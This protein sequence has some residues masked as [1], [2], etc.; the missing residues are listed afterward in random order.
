MTIRAAR[1]KQW[2]AAAALA[3]VLL[4]L[5]EWGAGRGAIRA[6]FF[7]P[8]S[9][10]WARFLLLAE[11]GVLSR[12]TAATLMRVGA[13][14]VLSGL[15]GIALG[16]LMGFSATVRHGL[17]PIISFVYP[18]PAVLL[19]PVAVSAFG[20]SEA[21][22]ILTSAITPFFLVSLSTM[23]GVLRIEPTLLEAARNFGA[24]GW[25]LF[26][27]VLL[28]GALPF[29]FTGLRLG[30]GFSLIVVL[31]VEILLSPTGLGAYLW[32]MWELLRVENVYAALLVVAVIGLLSTYGLDWLGSR[33]LPW[34]TALKGEQP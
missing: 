2:L 9:R 34:H 25:R 26:S 30:L 14:F 32:E 5:W 4:L 19:L 7:P 29:I 33:L 31:A 15:P 28:P 21:A 10:I 23:S 3:A 17:S 24:S 20:R 8:P 1:W 16:L 22:L 6:F 12:H 27:K 18:V 13:A 11:S